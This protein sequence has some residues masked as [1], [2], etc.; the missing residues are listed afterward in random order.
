MARRRV[1]GVPDTGD[2]DRD[3]ALALLSDEDRAWLERM[4]VEYREVLD[5]LRDR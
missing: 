5:Y 4:L 2:V 3:E 1:G